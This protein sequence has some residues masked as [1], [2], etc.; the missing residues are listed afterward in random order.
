MVVEFLIGVDVI[1]REGRIILF[2]FRNEYRGD[3]DVN[4][5]LFATDRYCQVPIDFALSQK[6]GLFSFFGDT[7]NFAAVGDFIVIL[8]R[9]EFFWEIFEQCRKFCG[10]LRLESLDRNE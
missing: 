4:F 6:C 5:I 3:E 1:D 10:H 8:F 2:G 7:A 9:V